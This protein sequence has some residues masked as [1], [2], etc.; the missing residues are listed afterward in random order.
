MHRTCALS[1]VERTTFG[2]KLRLCLRRSSLSS[3]A[4]S[5]QCQN[6]PNVM[7][8]VHCVQVC[9]KAELR[10]HHVNVMREIALDKLGSGAAFMARHFFYGAPM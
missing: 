6:A 9:A 3:P 10:H 8:L 4:N 7:P 5:V 1:G 2:G